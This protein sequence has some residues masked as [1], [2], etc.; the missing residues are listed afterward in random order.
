ARR[1]IYR[2]FNPQ[3]VGIIAESLLSFG[4]PVQ[5]R[6]WAVPILRAEMTASLGMSEPGAGSDLASLTTRAVPDGDHFV[7]NG[8]KVW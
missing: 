1:R 8:Q 5:K 3:G 6:R 2:S 7:V 4:T